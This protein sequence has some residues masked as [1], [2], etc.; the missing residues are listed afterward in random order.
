MYAVLAHIKRY[1]MVVIKMTIIN[2]NFE[3]SELQSILIVEA[4]VLI[5][6][7]HFCTTIESLNYGQTAKKKKSIHFIRN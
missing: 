6:L 3:N 5:Y 7:V 4:S 1:V 2:F